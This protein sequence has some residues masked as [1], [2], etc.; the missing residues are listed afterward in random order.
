VPVPIWLLHDA[1]S[2]PYAANH[3]GYEGDAT[4]NS[5]CYRSWEKDVAEA[6]ARYFNMAPKESL[7]CSIQ[8][9]RIKNSPV[10]SV[11]SVQQIRNQLRYPQA[12][13]QPIPYPSQQ[14]LRQP[15]PCL[16]Y[17]R[18][19]TPQTGSMTA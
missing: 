18:Q 16:G 3:D 19:G 9:P 13:E 8:M 2:K 1:S 7:A 5:D 4:L 11:N 6:T 10:A 12:N 17:G 15:Q 14:P